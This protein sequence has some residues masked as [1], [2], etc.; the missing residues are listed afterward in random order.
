MSRIL[1]SCVSGLIVLAVLTAPCLAEQPTVF[2]PTGLIRV[3]GAYTAAPGSMAF[4]G[5]LSS[6]FQSVNMVVGVIDRL[7][8]SAAWVHQDQDGFFDSSCDEWSSGG[9]E[10][11]TI[12]S[13]KYRLWGEESRGYALAAGIFDITNEFNSSVF[14]TVEKTFR[15]GDTCVVGMAGF[16]EHNSLVDGLFAGAEVFLGR[17]YRLMMEYDGEDF[18]AAVHLPVKNKFDFGIGILSDS[19]YGSA[20]YYLR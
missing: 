2:G 13:G 3:P 1:I 5:H 17:D 18:N 4:S 19:L 14:A 7:E 20:T 15:V 16:G 8:L 10:S 12:V 9:S 11:E 6:D